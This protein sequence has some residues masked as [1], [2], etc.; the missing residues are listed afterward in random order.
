MKR[1][2]P[3]VYHPVNL[4]FY[5]GQIHLLP[6]LPPLQS[7]LNCRIFN[8][9][10]LLYHNYQFMSNKILQFGRPD[11]TYFPFRPDGA[12]RCRRRLSR[13]SGPFPPPPPFPPRGSRSGFAVPDS[14]S[15]VI[16]SARGSA[17]LPQAVGRKSR[18]ERARP[19]GYR[20]AAPLCAIP[21]RDGK[22]TPP[23]ARRA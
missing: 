10:T 11:G 19:R 1:R 17:P 13:F 14:G 9:F 5:H 16:R 6:P 2:K 20:R 7:D 23:H 12:P 15:A 3:I 21:R 22:A 8:K 18:G 4:I